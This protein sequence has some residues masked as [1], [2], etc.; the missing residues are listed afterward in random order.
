MIWHGHPAITGRLRG[1]H[2][3]T[4]VR[5]EAI[6]RALS[7]SARTSYRRPTAPIRPLRRIKPPQTSPRRSSGLIDRISLMRDPVIGD[8]RHCLPRLVGD[9]EMQ[10]RLPRLH[11]VRD[12]FRVSGDGRHRERRIQI[13]AIFAFVDDDVGASAQ[14]SPPSAPASTTGP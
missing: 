7:A 8:E 14:L 5:S 9:G 11:R 13:V 4:R 1:A 6:F 12:G 2:P 3:Q 10:R